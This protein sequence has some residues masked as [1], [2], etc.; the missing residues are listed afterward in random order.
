MSVTAAILAGRESSPDP[1]GAGRRQRPRGRS[2]DIP[3][4]C[5]HR[6]AV[7]SDACARAA[8]GRQPPAPAAP[9]RRPGTAAC[10]G[11]HRARADCRSSGPYWPAGGGV[12]SGD[13]VR[14]LRPGVRG[15]RRGEPQPAAERRRRAIYRSLADADTAAASGFLAGAQEPARRR[16]R[17]EKDITHASKLLI[18]A[19]SNTG[20]SSESGRQIAT[21]NEELP[22]YTGLIERPAP[23][24]GR[25]CRSAAPICGTRTSR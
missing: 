8:A 11:D 4:E 1:P 9:G 24:T 6:A 16:E 12:R 10:G 17:Y 7:G 3:A 20:G 23:T 25:A 14:D 18:K 13:R 19:A 22:R 21:L 2:R 5:A 15:R